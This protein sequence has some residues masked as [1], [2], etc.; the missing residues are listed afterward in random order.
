[1]PDLPLRDHPKSRRW[2][3]AS[4][5]RRLGI[6]LAQVD[7]IRI[8]LLCEARLDERLDAE[9]RRREQSVE[10]TT[11]VLPHGRMERCR[12]L[13]RKYLAAWQIPKSVQIKI[14]PVP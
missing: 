1:M 7:R 14:Q 11:Q 12:G 3:P 6:A 4:E 8:V 10:L 13:G 5:S 2:H 9:H